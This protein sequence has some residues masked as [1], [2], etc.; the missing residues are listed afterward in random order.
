MKRIGFHLKVKPERIDEYR[1][2]HKAVW[3]EMRE[4]LSRQ[5]WH[6]YS[7]FM[8]ADGTLF[9]YVEV[10]ESF[11]AV[12]AGMAQEEINERWQKYMDGFFEIPEGR[13]ADQ[14]MQEL[15]EVFH[16]D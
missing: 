5:G 2:R 14:A 6:N 10:P 8:Q 9:G 12:L 15:E 7:L 3:P 13:H 16:L 11:E 4:A 1:E